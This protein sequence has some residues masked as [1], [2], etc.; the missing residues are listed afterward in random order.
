METKPQTIIA[1]A[2]TVKWKGIANKFFSMKL[3]F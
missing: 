2:P 1:S 3:I